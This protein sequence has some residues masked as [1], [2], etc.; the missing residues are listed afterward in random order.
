MTILDQVTP[1]IAVLGA[2]LGILNTVMSWRKWR[3]DRSRLKISAKVS[4][5]DS[6][7]VPGD[8]LRLRV[9]LLNDGRRAVQIRKVF[10]ITE[11][12]KWIE[13]GGISVKLIRSTI[14]PT[15]LQHE[16]LRLEEGDRHD[17]DVDPLDLSFVQSA[18]QS[19]RRRLMICAVDSMDREH[20]A[21]AQI[22]DE[23]TIKR[24]ERTNSAA[25]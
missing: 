9:S 17:F 1:V 21:H 13:K 23:E 25:P 2:L 6:I 14:Q 12:N 7:A 3:A 15:N 22:P 8:H 4:V 20:R 10:I 5:S 16:K 18:R 11:E 24:L 19:R